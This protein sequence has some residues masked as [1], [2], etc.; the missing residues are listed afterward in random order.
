MDRLGVIVSLAHVSLAPESRHQSGS[1]GCLLQE[2]KWVTYS[3]TWSASNWSELGTVRP[4]AAVL[5]LM[6]SSYLR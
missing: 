3:I 4:R 5:R 2:R 6:T 1:S